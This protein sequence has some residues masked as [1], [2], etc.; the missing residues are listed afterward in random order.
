[1]TRGNRVG[2]ME[3]VISELALEEK[4][5]GWRRAEGRALQAEKKNSFLDAGKSIKRGVWR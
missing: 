5:M 1:M 3:E 4:L 2:F